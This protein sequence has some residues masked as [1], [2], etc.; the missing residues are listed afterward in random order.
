MVFGVI[1]A[2]GRGFEGMGFWDLEV[3]KLLKSKINRY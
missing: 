3:S 2:M 1:L